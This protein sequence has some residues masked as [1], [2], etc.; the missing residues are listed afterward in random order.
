METPPSSVSMP[1]QGGTYVPAPGNETCYYDDFGNEIANNTFTHDG[2]FGNPT[3][4]D[5]ADVSGASPN[6]STDGNCFHDNVDT[7]GTLTSDPA[8]IDSFNKCGSNYLGEPIASPLFAQFVCAAAAPCGNYPRPTAI[9]MTPPPPQA[10]MPNPCSGVPKNAWCH[11]AANRPARCISGHNVVV[12]TTA[13][14]KLMVVR[15]TVNGHRVSARLNGRS[16]VLV[17]LPRRL[18]GRFTVRVV[19]RLRSGLTR[20]TV[21]HLR[22]C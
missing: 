10:T 21:R 15:V 14:G 2:F 16:S 4:G 8:N 22:T 13:P 6:S 11:A 17:N 1:C 7:S 19:E 18:R 9:P 12:H 5:I 3:N 20:V